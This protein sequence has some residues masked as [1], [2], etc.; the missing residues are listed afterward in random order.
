LE[1]H[2]PPGKNQSPPFA[3]MRRHPRFKWQA[4]IRVY[5][6]S[7]GLLKGHTLD[8][9]EAGVSAMLRLEPP[10][11]EVVQLEFEL[12]TGSVAIR[13]LVRHKTAFRYGFQFVEPD[14]EGAIKA[15]CLQF[16]AERGNDQDS[17]LCP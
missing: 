16:A 10:V 6:R 9:S 15:A 5:S 8:I 7:A 12:P 13:A 1:G 14:P 2:D 3:E 17:A 4:A 11:G